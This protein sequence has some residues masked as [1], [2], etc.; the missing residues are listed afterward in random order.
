MGAG[1]LSGTLCPAMLAQA[2]SHTTLAGSQAHHGMP[3]LLD[4]QKLCTACQTSS[5]VSPPRTGHTVLCF[6][7]PGISLQCAPRAG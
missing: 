1:R 5:Y 6:V 7:L 4:C 3:V 2:T